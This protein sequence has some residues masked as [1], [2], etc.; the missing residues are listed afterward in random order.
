MGAMGGI[1]ESGIGKVVESL[2][3]DCKGEV[4]EAGL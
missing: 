1:I 2:R 4:I 3:P